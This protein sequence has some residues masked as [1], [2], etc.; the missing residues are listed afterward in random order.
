MARTVEDAA[1]V[2]D[3][4]VGYDEKDSLTYHYPIARAPKSYTESLVPDALRGARI[5][6]VT[7][8]LGRDDDE[9]EGPVNE[10]MRD[11]VE[12]LRGA[13][14]EVIEVQIPNLMDHIMATS[15]YVA[16]T[17]YDINQFLAERPDAPIRTLQEIHEKKRYHPALDLLEAC[18]VGPDDPTTD[19]SYHAMLTAREAFTRAVVNVMAENDLVALT[20]P[21]VQV[22]PP[23]REQLATKVWTTLTFPTNTL[24]ASQAWLPAIVV[25]AGFTKAGLPVGIEFVAV[26]YDEPT[27]FRLGYGFEQATRHRRAPESTPALS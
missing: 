11:A 21:S 9:N 24:I 14:A 1:K 25:P 2:M 19:P 26:P 23:S 4:L 10:V 8:A 16:R 22:A 20:F 13:G 18:I 15:L 5:G 12:A 7:N 6:L 3:V 27:V 17:K